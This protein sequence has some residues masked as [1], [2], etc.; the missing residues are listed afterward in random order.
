MDEV[1]PPT[2]AEIETRSAAI[3]QGWSEAEHERRRKG[4]IPDRS[5]SRVSP[6]VAQTANV[7]LAV[8]LERKRKLA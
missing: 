6:D 1:K 2:P 8:S 7:Y 4:L 3:R 5:R